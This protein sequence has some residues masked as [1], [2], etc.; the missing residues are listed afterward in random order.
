MQEKICRHNLSDNELTDDQCLPCN[1]IKIINF[2]SVTSKDS[3][4]NFIDQLEESNV[5]PGKEEK[6]KTKDTGCGEN[7]IT[8]DEKAICAMPQQS[9]HWVCKQQIF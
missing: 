9:E 7:D 5:D 1:G 4:A 3:S 2:Q 8:T 6:L